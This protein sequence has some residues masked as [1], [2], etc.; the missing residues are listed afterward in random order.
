L[1]QETKRTDGLRIG[2]TIGDPAGI[3]PEVVLKSLLYWHASTTKFCLIGPRALWDE[4]TAVLSRVRP[5]L[6]K[7]FRDVERSADWIETPDPEA[8]KALELGRTS[9]RCGAVARD[10]IAAG[11]NC[12]LSGELD[13]LVTA[14][15][16]KEGFAAA[17]VEH[18]GHTELLAEL[19]DVEDTTMALVGGNLRV[20]LATIHV[21]FIKVPELLSTELIVRKARHLVA[22]LKLRGIENPSIG[23]CGLNPHASE[24]GL[25]GDE[26]QRIL[27]PAVAEARA[28]GIRLSNPVPGD[29]VF[30][31]AL[32][33]RFDAVL[34]LYHDQG[35]IPVKTLAFNS[36][37][38]VTLGL[39]I[40]RTSPD[41]GT[42]FGL[43]GKGVARPGS[44][45]AALRLAV[46][47][48]RHAPGV[49]W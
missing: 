8:G 10:A 11:V 16:S 31:D 6:V 4:T 40:I 35:L 3:G 26:E 12:C 38:N 45:T 24:G 41:H 1:A 43:A 46:D 13:G 48:A 9:A 28:Q 20:A 21:P 42:A 2:V 36:A 49:V 5:D 18:P 34:A 22:F 32:E 39:P 30:Y 7:G 47:M 23:L 25:F 29:T 15:I 27:V 33:G 14:P 19:C 37:V 17:G 44:M